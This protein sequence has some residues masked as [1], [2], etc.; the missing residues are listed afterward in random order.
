MSVKKI[1]IIQSNYIPWKGYFDIIN[2]VDHFVLYDDVQFN[3]DN[4]RN[5][6]KI[7]TPQGTL[8]MTIPVEQKSLSQKIQDTVIADSYWKKRHF[9]TL[10][11]NYGRAEY[12]R[13]YKEFFEELYLNTNEK[14]LTLVNYRFLKAI[15]NLL[16]IN[17][18]FSF[19]RDYTLCEGKMERVV[20]LTEQLDGDIFVCGPTAKPYINQP[21]FDLANIGIEW[22]EY[23][24]Y[25]EY[26]QLFCPAF[27]HEVSIL[28]LIFNEGV[29]G[30]RRYMLT[31]KE[32]ISRS[33]D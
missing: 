28:D 25:Q 5:R 1:A 23:D 22:F 15:C 2:E 8:W 19:S 31:S 26:N 9:K 21:V 12:F 14:Y 13:E 32:S 27:I 7:K 3:H 17:T 16:N 33:S 4:W 24:G 30:T 20:D 10:C 11:Q 18:E 29:E 6:N